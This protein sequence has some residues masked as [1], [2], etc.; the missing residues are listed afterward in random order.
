MFRA[1]L[2]QCFDGL[3]IFGFEGQGLKTDDALKK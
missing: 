1:F 3:C 2:F